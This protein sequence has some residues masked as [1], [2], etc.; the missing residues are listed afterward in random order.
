MTPYAEKL[1][2]Y[3]L[4]NVPDARTASGGKEVV[5]RCRF[6][7]DSKDPTSR[8]LY[9]GMPT[10][11]KPAMY[12]CFRCNESGLVNSKFLHLLNIYDTSIMSDL[13]EHN[14]NLEKVLGYKIK[15]DQN[16]VYRLSNM[17]ISDNELSYAKLGY[18]NKRLGLNL[19]F[20]DLIENKIVLNLHDLLQS[21]NIT[22]YTRHINIVDQLNESFLGFISLDNAFINMRNLRPGKV[23]ESIDKRY[24]NYNIFGKMNNSQRYYVIPNKLNTASIEPI[25][26]HIAEGP[27]DILSIYY[28]MVKTKDNNLF[29]S[30][31]GKAY[32]NVLKYIIGELGLI[33]IEV[34]IYPDAD[35][36]NYTIQNIVQYLSVFQIDFYIHRNTYPG[37]KDFGV[38]LNKIKESIIKI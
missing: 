24:V 26:V 10:E 23:F 4:E 19:T 34:H 16:M 28:N 3:L 5:V 7:Q 12:N 29:V 20:A 2:E 14:N 6:C 1:K 13:K 33:N 38:S 18:I 21:N 25:K 32:L 8:H 17:Y 11:T 30:I 36:Q 31:C 35:I 27:F 22:N 37:E 9:I 15:D